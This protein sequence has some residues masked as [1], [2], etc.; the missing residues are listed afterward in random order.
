MLHKT[1]EGKQ[2]ASLEK[3]TH[4]AYSNVD[5]LRRPLWLIKLVA[6]VAQS[7]SQ[8]AP[9]SARNVSAASNNNPSS[10]PAPSSQGVPSSAIPAASSSR[11][12]AAP[13]SRPSAEPSI[14][15]S[16][17]VSSAPSSRPSGATSSSD[18]RIVDG[19]LTCGEYPQS[20]CLESQIADQI[21]T[22]PTD[23]RG[24]LLIAGKKYVT[25]GGK[26]FNVEP[27]RWKPLEREGDCLIALSEF[28]LEESFYNQ[29][30][31]RSA[32]AG[33][34]LEN[35]VEN[36]MKKRLFG[37]S[38]DPRILEC[39]PLKFEHV[40]KIHLTDRAWVTEGTEYAL[41]DWGGHRRPWCYWTQSPWN[42]S[43]TEVM[44]VRDDRYVWDNCDPRSCQ[45]V[46][47]YIKVRL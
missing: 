34:D 7:F 29:A 22:A 5:F 20:E 25:Y 32:Y 14:R 45:G 13:S 30:E 23:E 9:I 36:T 39:G 47:L 4:F 27:V 38:R 40:D 43:E 24:Y 3:L 41:R 8:A 31:A 35:F 33:S 6:P 26:I 18:F 46:R 28:V 12:S 15:P 17:P 37:S 42:D 11:P 44:L 21:W 19:F 16:E 10:S 1:H 2:L